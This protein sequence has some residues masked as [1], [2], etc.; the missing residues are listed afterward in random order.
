MLGTDPLSG[1]LNRLFVSPL[2]QGTSIGVKF[3]SSLVGLCA[4]VLVVIGGLIATDQAFTG[5]SLG[6]LL[7]VV[8][9]IGFGLIMFILAGGLWIGMEWAWSWALILYAGSAIGGFV[10]GIQTVDYV[11][12]LS[13]G[14]SGI[15][16]VYLYTQ[17]DQFK[18]ARQQ[19]S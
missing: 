3:L 4:G 10:A 11:P 17:Q 19:I 6:T 5:I 8:F 1:L 15:I 2:S 16:A 9:L 18:D 13:A 14:T 12:L 7:P